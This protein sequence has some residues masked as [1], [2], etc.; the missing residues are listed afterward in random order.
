[1]RSNYNKCSLYEHVRYVILNEWDPIGIRGFEE[2][3]DE[4][5]SYVPEVC[6]LLE[7]NADLNSLFDYLWQLETGHM[8]LPGDRGKTTEISNRLI[9]IND[10]YKLI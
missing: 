9:D 5:D 3:Q 2:A 6:R 4:Y 1:M 7:D 10:M 8:G